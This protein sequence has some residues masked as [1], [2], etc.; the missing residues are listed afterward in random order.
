MDDFERDLNTLLD[1]FDEPSDHVRPELERLR[2]HLLALRTENRVKINHSI[3][4]LVYTK[5]LIEG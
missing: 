5:Y 1:R 2:T 3:M 4:E